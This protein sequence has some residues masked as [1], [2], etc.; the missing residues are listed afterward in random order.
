MT[1]FQPP[2]P[3]PGPAGDVPPGPGYWKASDGNWYPP[4]AGS[5][6][7]GWASAPTVPPPGAP[8]WGSAPTVPPPGAPGWGSAPTV[9]P[10]GYAP[11]DVNGM[12]TAALVLGIV[13]L[14]LFWIPFL[15]PLLAILGVIFGLVGISKAKEHPG[16]PLIGRAKAGLVT[17]IIGTVVGIGFFVLVVVAVDNTVNE[18]ERINGINTDPANGVCD[19]ERFLQDPDC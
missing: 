1:D 16:A 10:P 4:Q 11:G 12:A 18:L 19:P 17:G 2:F 3:P 13:G 14:C 15:G 7:S 8:G 6:A 9:P 5:A